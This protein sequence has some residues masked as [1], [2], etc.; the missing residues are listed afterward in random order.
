M[1]NLR[2]QIAAS[3]L[4]FTL[5]INATPS[6]AAP[7]PGPLTLWYEQPATVAIEHALP[8]GN[9]HLG[10]LVF[11]G[12][13][14]ERIQLNESSLWTGDAN[15]SGDYGSMGAYQALG[16][17]QL[18][19]PNN[20]TIQVS[21]PGTPDP[22][23][24]SE[25]VGNSADGNPATKWC[26]R[27]GGGPVVWL[28]ELPAAVVA[29]SYTL[30]SANDMPARDPRTWE[31]AGSVDGKAWTVLDTH[32]DQE[33][34]AK[35]YES[36]T[37][38][39]ANTTPYRFYRWTVLKNNGD[40]LFQ[41]ADFAIGESGTRSKPTTESGYRRSLDLATAIT[42]TDFVD[43]GVHIHREVLA[44]HP[45]DVIAI[46]WTADKPGA[47]SG[48]VELKGAHG[49]T[50]VASGSSLSFSGKLANGL[51]YETL[52]RVVASGGAVAP[53]QGRVTLRG[54]DN[55][56][57]YVAAGTDYAMNAA[58]G[59]RGESPHARVVAAVDNAA[60][61]GYE[62]IKQEHI[63]DYQSLFSRVALDVGKSTD[64]QRALPTDK[65]K[66][67]AVTAVDPE[68]ESLL[69]QYGR[70]L[71]ISCSRPGGLPANLQG[72]WNDSNNPPWHS[73]YHA[74]INIQMN[75][76]PA[77]VANL[78]E[79]HV[80]LFDLVSSQAPL[81]RK[82]TATA[83][84]FALPNAGPVRGFAVRT[85]HNTM[86]GMGWQ[87]DDTANAWYC[88]HYWE[89]FA[90]G[91]DKAYL[92]TVAYPIMKETVQFW[93]DHL[94][95]LPD[96]RLVVPHG[97][98]PEHGP[99]QDGVSYNQQIVYNLFTNYVAAAGALGVDHDYS[100]KVAGMRDKLAG[101]QVGSWGQL[102]EWLTE[103][104]D[105]VLDTP[106]DHHRHTSHLFAVYPGAQITWA[107]TPKLAEAASK[108]LNS[109]GIDEASDVREWSF[110][111]RSAL[112]ARLQHGWKA[113]LMVA[114]LLADRNTCVNLFGLHP[115][116]QIDGN[117]GITAGIAE[118]LLQ[119][120]EGDVSLLPAL[121]P[122]WPTGSVTGLRARGGFTVDI[123]WNEGDLTEATIRSSLGGPCTVRYGDKAVT[124]ATKTGQVVKIGFGLALRK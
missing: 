40:A 31:L 27:H 120:H 100:V 112:Y 6:P 96:G 66:R 62:D 10:G 117:F 29:T 65:R 16:A 91:G 15:P 76:W 77:E 123:A 41:I 87:W 33:P 42:S 67:E 82:A 21:S 99:R 79:C 95:T 57:V 20:D 85:S 18:I 124:I 22:E 80:P 106:N 37:F 81:W 34:F 46:R 110:A 50:T 48:I 113:H 111:W 75:Y 121:P 97:W 30:T 122:V 45:A 8:V 88:Q 47:L 109:R 12:V 17:L 86:G 68:L 58:T 119:S 83:P 108:S 23:N 84:E 74:N 70:Y 115:P 94:K 56:T 26:L 53:G 13:G 101:P 118:M 69:F 52:A 14:V 92:R 43:N 55:V 51:R 44:S 38:T 93:E 24:P 103:L 25:Y 1:L 5:L 3:V 116:M 89:H 39:F 9:G 54:C 90:F 36:R 73:D 60:K 72:L 11:G 4:L 114:Q 98:S 102:L 19:L 32:A 61:R 28:G 64:A 7:V 2:C 35:R 49:E 105:P 78:S 59:Y 71:L 63:K 107:K 104:H